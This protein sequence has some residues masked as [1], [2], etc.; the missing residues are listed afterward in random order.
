MEA[1]ELDELLGLKPKFDLPPAAR[2]SLEEVGVISVSE[3]GFPAGSLDNQPGALVKAALAGNSGQM[4]SRWGHILL[5]RALASRYDAPDGL[6]AVEFAAERAALLN[7]MGEPH[8]ARALVQDIDTGNYNTALTGAALNAYLGTGDIVGICPVARL[9]ATVREGAEWDMIQQVC[10]A[11][12]GDER[13]AVRQLDRMLSR[14]EVSRI[15]VL[16]AQRFAGAAGDGRRAVNIE[17]DDVEELTP[18]RFAFATALGIQPPANLLAATNGAFDARAAISPALTVTQRLSAADSAA[19]RGV[20]SSSS[21]VDLYSQAYSAAETG[22]EIS[23]EASTLRDAYVENDPAARL[24]AIKSL[25]DDG[26]YYGRQVLTS[27][28]AA[29]LPV[30]EAFQEDAGALIAS[31]LAAGLDR[32]ALQWATVV[33]EGSHGWGQLALAQP[34]RDAPVGQGA[35]GDFASEDETEGQLRAR[36]FIAGLAGLGRIEGSDL[37]DLADDY[38]LDLDRRTRW[39]DMIGG[40]AEVNNP[41]LVAMLAG[42]GMQGDSWDKM[43]PRHLYHIVRSLNAVGLGA[44]ARMIAAEAVA[45]T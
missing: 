6:S 45:R 11:F 15:D 41:S 19:E 7:R 16:L 25:W 3:G 22:A 33:L 2:R 8:I 5:R 12:G 18:W 35:I 29:R 42:L 39:S 20:L 9:K 21:F 34:T 43:T 1:D 38:A 28:A 31:M 24:A 4:V 26:E 32:N 17:W 10:G 36:L 30:D 13:R 37:A 40:A 27:Y 44:E 23:A 14:N